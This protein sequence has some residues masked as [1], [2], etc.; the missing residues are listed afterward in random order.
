M[1]IGRTCTPGTGSPRGQGTSWSRWRAP[2]HPLGVAPKRRALCRAHLLHQ[3]VGLN[4]PAPAWWHWVSA[5]TCAGTVRQAPSPALLPARLPGHEQLLPAQLL[6]CWR[7]REGQPSSAHFPSPAFGA[8][9]PRGP[10]SALRD[11]ALGAG[12]G[13]GSPGRRGSGCARGEHPSIP[14]RSWE[15]LAQPCQ[16]VGR[17]REQ[18]ALQGLREG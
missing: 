8:A 9:V 7:S 11:G 3:T 4:R 18:P 14:A 5:G 12:A 15:C 6:L 1:P 10:S 16:A 2:T 13:S 17:Q